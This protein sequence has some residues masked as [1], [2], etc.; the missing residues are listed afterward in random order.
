MCNKIVKTYSGLLL[1]VLISACTVINQEIPTIKDFD[2]EKYQGQWYEIARLD[3]SFE[4][5]LIN[6]TANYKM[7][8]SWVEV[9][10]RGFNTEENKWTQ[11][12]GR[13][14]FING[15]KEGLLKVAF[16]RPFYG[17]YQ[18]NDLVTNNEG[19]YIASLV[20]GPD[21]EYAWILSRTKKLPEDIKERFLFK[22]KQLGI[23]TNELI[24][25]KQN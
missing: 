24:W 8:G 16:F 14:E 9:I 4:D 22:M 3:H 25:V 5:G 7:K 20:I 18:I 13:A 19:D 11:A 10:N 12:T 21:L 15:P 6:V 1:I 23:K 17:A 2:I